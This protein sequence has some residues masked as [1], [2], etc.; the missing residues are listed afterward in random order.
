MCFECL[1]VYFLLKTASNFRFPFSLRLQVHQQIKEEISNKSSVLRILKAD[2]GQTESVTPIISLKSLFISP[3]QLFFSINWIRNRLLRVSFIGLFDAI[4]HPHLN[5]R[6]NI[7]LLATSQKAHLCNQFNQVLHCQ[8]QKHYFLIKMTLELSCF[9]KKMQNFWALR[10]PPPHPCA[11]GG[12]GLCPQTPSLRRLGTSPS[13]PKTAPLLRI[14]AY[15]P[16]C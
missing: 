1:N 16:D 10:A 11:S 8:F 13:G 3:P 12:W 6:T 4:I 2:G 9:C 14:S 15:A 7:L 5:K